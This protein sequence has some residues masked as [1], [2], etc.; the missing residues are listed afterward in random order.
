M[1]GVAAC[2]T[3]GGGGGHVAAVPDTMYARTSD[4][5]HIAY[6]VIGEGPIHLLEPSGGS[7]V[8]I[9]VRDE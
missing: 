3:W 1:G 8:S 5:A 4:G 2:K 9:D 6:Q 7:Y